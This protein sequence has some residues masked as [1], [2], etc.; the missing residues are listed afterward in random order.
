M[1]E[2]GNDTYVLANVL[3]GYEELRSEIFL[4]DDFVVDERNGAD[5]S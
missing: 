1:L 5:A 4:R 2:G 3:F